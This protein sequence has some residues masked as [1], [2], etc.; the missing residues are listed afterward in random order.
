MA[1][2]SAGLA[3]RKADRL[4]LVHPTRAAWWATWSIPKGL[5]E[6]GERDLDA[7][8]RETHEETGL[9]IDPATVDPTP[10]EIP[11]VDRRGHV[12]KTVV[13][14][15]CDGIALPEE[16]PALQRAEVNAAGWFDGPAAER[17]ILGRLR[18]VLG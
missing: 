7:A 12:T 2:R 14:F 11:Y 9:V 16:M 13:W 10:R 15:A 8:I 3:I 18:G 17:R 6:P 4:L 5:V 1:P